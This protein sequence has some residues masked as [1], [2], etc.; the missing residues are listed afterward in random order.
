MS[1]I[2]ETSST[3]RMDEKI[4]QKARRKLSFV[5][6][7]HSHQ[8]TFSQFYLTN[9]STDHLQLATDH[10]NQFIQQSEQ[11]IFDEQQSIINEEN[12]IQNLQNEIT[13]LQTNIDSL[14]HEIDKLTLNTFDTLARQS[15]GALIRHNHVLKESIEHINHILR[16]RTMETD[17]SFEH[18]KKDLTKQQEKL[19]LLRNQLDVDH[20]KLA[21]NISLLKECQE[22]R[23]EYEQKKIQ[24]QIELQTIQQTQG[25]SFFRFFPEL[26]LLFDLGDYVQRQLRLQKLQSSVEQQVR[27]RNEIQHL[28]KYHQPDRLPENKPESDRTNDRTL[29]IVNEIDE[30]I[31]EENERYPK[32]QD[33]TYDY[34]FNKLKEHGEE[35]DDDDDKE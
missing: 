24:K 25:K 32:Q 8:P 26:L 1:L 33:Y 14:T 35:N 30:E 7:R 16:K 18:F 12:Q 10:L 29:E 11:Q 3:T 34:S 27:I 22:Q 2:Y 28:D 31:I 21:T 17:S 4:Y 20:N 19:F 6:N 15:E 9:H 5:D 23:N 13:H